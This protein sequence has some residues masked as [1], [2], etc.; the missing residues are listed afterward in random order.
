M[1]FVTVYYRYLV[2]ARW[3]RNFKSFYGIGRVAP[4]AVQ[5]SLIENAHLTGQIEGTISTGLVI[6]CI[7]CQS[8]VLAVCYNHHAFDIY[9]KPQTIE[10]DYVVVHEKAWDLLVS[11]FGNDV[12]FPRK[13]VLRG[14]NPIVDVYPQPCEV[15]QTDASSGEPGQDVKIVLVARSTTGQDLPSV[16]KRELELLTTSTIRVWIKVS[17]VL[18][19]CC[20]VFVRH[21]TTGLCFVQPSDAEEYALVDPGQ[22]MDELAGNDSVTELLVETQ[23]ADGTWT[24]ASASAASPADSIFPAPVTDLVAW[25]A[26]LKVLYN[27]RVVMAQ[28]ERVLCLLARTFWPARVSLS[29]NR[30]F[31]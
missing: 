26:G 13:V 25:R 7:I 8:V 24:R 29:T 3:F 19:L 9:C 2:S 10:E 17:R 18:K 23:A 11:W 1:I 28:L 20:V 4:G 6:L 12:A 21:L 15:R 27:F 31:C 16:L 5:P 22:S 30:Y 14:I